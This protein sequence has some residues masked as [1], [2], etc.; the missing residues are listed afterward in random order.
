MQYDIFLRGIKLFDLCATQ[1]PYE[2]L[3]SPTSLQNDILRGIKLIDFSDK[4][5]FLTVLL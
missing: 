5:T 3:R 4:P 1:Y 2:E